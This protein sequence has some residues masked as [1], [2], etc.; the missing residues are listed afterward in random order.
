LVGYLGGDT[1]KKMG[2]GVVLRRDW[3]NQFE[4]GSDKLYH[5]KLGDD[6]PSAEA[7]LP[8][9]WKQSGRRPMP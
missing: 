6:I 2:K 7:V 1:Q 9:R 3:L 4:S 5:P 8:N